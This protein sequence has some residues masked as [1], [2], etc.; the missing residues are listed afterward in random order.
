MIWDIR[1]RL[2]VFVKYGNNFSY[3]KWWRNN[4][5]ENPTFYFSFLRCVKI[6]KKTSLSDCIIFCHYPPRNLSSKIRCPFRY[7]FRF[8]WQKNVFRSTFVFH[9]N[10][11]AFVR[12]PYLLFRKKNLWRRKRVRRAIFRNDKVVQRSLDIFDRHWALSVMWEINE[13]LYRNW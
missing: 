8:T 13:Y 2:C 12:V 11:W 4:T 6:K 3:L 5:V 9:V 1:S 7:A 10:L